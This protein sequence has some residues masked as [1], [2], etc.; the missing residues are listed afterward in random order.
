MNYYILGF[1]VSALDVV[2]IG[3][4]QNLLKGQAIVHLLVANLHTYREVYKL[5]ANSNNT[6]CDP[7]TIR[8]H[9][10]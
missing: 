8:F 7:K 3:A 9:T 4:L 2:C 5:T 6:T 10:V 1:K